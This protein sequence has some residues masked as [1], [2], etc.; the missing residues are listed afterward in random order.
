MDP[1]DDK[2]A[3]LRQRILICQIVILMQRG[4]IVP[5]YQA[6]L[7]AQR[8]PGDSLTCQTFSTFHSLVKSIACQKEFPR[9]EMIRKA[10]TRSVIRA[11]K[12]TLFMKLFGEDEKEIPW[13]SVH[14]ECI[15]PHFRCTMTQGTMTMPFR[16]P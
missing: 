1:A 11:T 6:G 3:E 8:I 16:G 7:Y 12:D 4:V 15:L 10:D 2:T 14:G 5:T 13:D 9:G